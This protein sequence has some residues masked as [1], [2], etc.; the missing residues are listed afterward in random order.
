MRKVTFTNVAFVVPCLCI[1]ELGSG[2]LCLDHPPAV[3]TM[4]G[5]ALG[6]NRRERLLRAG[7]PDSAGYHSGLALTEDGTAQVGKHYHTSAHIREHKQGL[8]F[9][10]TMS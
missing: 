2:P 8:K 9:L 10:G 1:L 4:C 5:S 7:S 3:Y 6:A